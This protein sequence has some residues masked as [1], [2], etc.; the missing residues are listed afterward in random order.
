MRLI[1]L[2][3]FVAIQI[4][5]AGPSSLE[6]DICL[7]SRSNSSPQDDSPASDIN[8]YLTF[9][10][11]SFGATR[12]DAIELFG[13]PEWGE[14]HD[15]VESLYYLHHALEINID[16]ESGRVFQITLSNGHALSKNFPN[17]EEAT[18][19]LWR[20]VEHVFETYGPPQR[21][22]ASF[23]AYDLSP[24]E[25]QGEAVFYCPNFDQCRCHFIEVFWWPAT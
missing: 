23:Y 18:S 7:G 11:L 3:V 13:E 8:D 5:C 10:G 9:V 17:I 21:A 1:A 20:N 12:E 6:L 16:M 4:G 14:S 25:G 24:S 15:L 22:N 2:L 19:F